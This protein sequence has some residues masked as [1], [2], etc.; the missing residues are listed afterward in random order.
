M[1]SV[2]LAYV[3]PSPMPTLYAFWAVQLAV[4]EHASEVLRTPLAAAVRGSRYGAD[5]LRLFFSS[6]S[7][8]WPDPSMSHS[9]CIKQC[10]VACTTV[11]LRQ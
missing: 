1:F 2:V 9:A 11:S 4:W 8:T 5:E 10:A 6:W 3:E 7:D